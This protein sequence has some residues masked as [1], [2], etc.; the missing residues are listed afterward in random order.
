MW[1]IDKLAEQHILKAQ[2]EG[3]FKNL[4]GEGQPLKLEDNALV[5]VELRTAYRLLKNSGYLPPQVHLRREIENVEGLILLARNEDEKERHSRRLHALLFRLSQAG[6]S[7]ENLR[8]QKDY[9]QQLCRRL[10]GES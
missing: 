8:I 6:M 3:E 2:D 1:L 7:V 10:G 4:P 9:Y 5:P